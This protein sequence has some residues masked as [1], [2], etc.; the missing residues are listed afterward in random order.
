M[1]MGNAQKY[2]S[3]LYLKFKFNCLLNMAT[4]SRSQGEQDI[5][6]QFE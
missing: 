3:F 6:K 4:L 1:K 2:V 5:D